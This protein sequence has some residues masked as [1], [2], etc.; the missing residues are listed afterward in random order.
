MAK[1]KDGSDTGRQAGGRTN[2]GVSGNAMPRV[3]N[4]GKTVRIIPLGGVGEVGKNATAIECGQD[5]VIVDVGVK[6]P[7]D[8]QRASISSFPMS[9]IC[10]SGSIDFVASSSPMGTRTILARLP[11]SCPSCAHDGWRVPIYGS[12][13]TLGMVEAKLR[14][15]RVLDLAE[16]H[17]VEPG[18]VRKLGNISCEFISVAHSIPGA[19]FWR[20]LPRRV[21]WS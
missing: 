9:R 16:L 18:D 2:T 21:L 7:E 10:A 19:F 13:L 3:K 1:N 6:F 15:R 20:L 17:A 12:R 4:N 8:D 14:E 11:S 5:I